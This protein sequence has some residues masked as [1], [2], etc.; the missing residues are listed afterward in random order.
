[1]PSPPPYRSFAVG[2]HI[3]TKS[4][5]PTCRSATSG[6]PSTGSTVIGTNGSPASPH[7]PSQRRSMTTGE[8]RSASCCAAGPVVDD[9]AAAGWATPAPTV[10]ATSSSATASLSHVSLDIAAVIATYLLT[11]LDQEADRLGSGSRGHQ[12]GQRGAARP[13]EVGG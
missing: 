10:S 5:L 7:V 3:I 9:A 13:P 1:M 2:A 12:C 11:R 8:Y 6:L 4:P